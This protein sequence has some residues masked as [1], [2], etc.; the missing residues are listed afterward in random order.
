MAVAPSRCTAT[1]RGGRGGLTEAG[2]SED[3]SIA[4]DDDTG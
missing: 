1:T 4:G 2:E 3:R